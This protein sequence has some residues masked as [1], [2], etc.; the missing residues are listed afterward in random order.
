MTL[1]DAN[2]PIA[3]T[4]LALR[5]RGELTGEEVVLRIIREHQP[6]AGLPFEDTE[7]LRAFLGRL[8]CC[9]QPDSA[10]ALARELELELESPQTA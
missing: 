6:P 3:R 8:A 9:H 1:T 4:L 10:Q 5:A 2:R 7:Q